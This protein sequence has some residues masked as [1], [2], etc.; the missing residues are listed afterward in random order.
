MINLQAIMTN[1]QVEEFNPM[2][3]IDEYS[4]QVYKLCSSITFSKEDAEDLF[5][6]TFLRALEQT[7]KMEASGDYRGF[8]FSTA[9]YIWKSWKRKY[10][11]RK[12]L[13]PTESLSENT[14]SNTDIEGG[15]LKQEETRIVRELVDELP[16]NFKIPTILHYT[17]E[18]NIDDIAETMNIPSGTVKSRLFKAR[19]MIEKGLVSNE[20]K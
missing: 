11:R 16:D 7:K 13:V 19:K 3:L 1:E 6:E 20:Y 8:L 4:D 17:L 9:I 10:A 12:R 14:I 2:R 5:Q 18:M 15:Y